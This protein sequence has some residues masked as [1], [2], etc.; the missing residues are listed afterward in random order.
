MIRPASVLLIAAAIFAWAVVPAKAA[1]EFYMVI[2]NVKGAQP[3][4]MKTR[5]QISLQLRPVVEPPVA[6]PVMKGTE[7]A[8]PP[9]PKPQ[10]PDLL[11]AVTFCKGVKGVQ[12]VQLNKTA[13]TIIVLIPPTTGAEETNSIA[14]SL[15]AIIKSKMGLTVVRQPIVEPPQ[16][17]VKPLPVER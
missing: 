1:Y 14:E 16:V 3:D 15:I 8:T 7:T 4:T 13:K 9:T 11:K 10:E 17:P 2:E 6:H 5:P 12:N